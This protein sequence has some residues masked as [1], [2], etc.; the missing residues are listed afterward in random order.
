MLIKNLFSYFF[1]Y[2]CGRFNRGIFLRYLNLIIMLSNNFVAV[3]C[4]LPHRRSSWRVFA[5]HTRC[6]ETANSILS[7]LVRTSFEQYHE[8]PFITTQVVTD[9][10]IDV[11]SHF[12]TF[13]RRSG[14]RYV[15]RYEIV[16]DLPF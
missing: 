12:V 1:A 3:T 6:C 15:L 14:T 8:H 13:P 9:G 16:N 2:L 11:Y 10:V 7:N 4:V 5:G